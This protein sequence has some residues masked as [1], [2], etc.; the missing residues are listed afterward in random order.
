MEHREHKKTSFILKQF[1]KNEVVLVKLEAQLLEYM[2]KHPELIPDPPV[3]PPGEFQKI[4]EEFNKREKKLVVRRQLIIRNWGF[5]LLQLLQKPLLVAML[6]IIW[7][8]GSNEYRPIKKAS[9]FNQVQ[10]T[11]VRNIIYN[12]LSSQPIYN[13]D[14]RHYIRSQD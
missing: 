1:K 8:M 4:M 6:A 3:A 11:I 7:L 12:G 10:R 14:G 13:A 9:H 5:K 2:Q